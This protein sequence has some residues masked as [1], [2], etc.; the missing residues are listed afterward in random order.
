[1]RAETRKRLAEIINSI[2]D[3]K[4]QTEKITVLMQEEIHAT[5]QSERAGRITKFKPSQNGKQ[6]EA[7][8]QEL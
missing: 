6:H 4:E 3:R 5:L 1:M 2:G 8:M 7:R